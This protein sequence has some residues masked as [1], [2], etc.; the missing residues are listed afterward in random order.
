VLSA[1]EVGGVSQVPPVQRVN[2]ADVQSDKPVDAQV[3]TYRHDDE[4]NTRTE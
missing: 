3:N 4:A 2:R 1:R